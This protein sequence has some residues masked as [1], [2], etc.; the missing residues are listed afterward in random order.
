MRLSALVA[1]RGGKIDPFTFEDF[2][3]VGNKLSTD[4]SRLILVGGQ[5]LETWG[6]YFDVL[7]PTG[8][9]H[10]LTEDTDWLGGKRDAQW[11]CQLL[12]RDDTELTFATGDDVGT[13]SAL[14]Y[15]KRPDGRVLMMDF[16]HAIVGP[17]NE[18]IRKLAVSIE[19][20][21]VT[22]QVMHPLLCLESRLENLRLLP[23]KRNG[24]GVMQAAWAINIVQAYIQKMLDLGDLEQGAKACRK[25]AENAEYKAGRYCF[26]AFGLDPLQAVSPDVVTRIGGRFETIEWP[27][28]M[29]R[30]KKKRARWQEIAA[31]TQ[32]QL[33]AGAQGK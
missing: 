11:L 20:S 5:A 27:K 33:A 15:L 7:A 22:L 6:I 32:P 1:K 4:P 13:S 24:N 30:I 3:F 8:D 31:R 16:L 26:I 9:R 21:G 14:A 23:S 18:E 29:T 28:V 12:G 25:V 2:L 19:V 17:S 10:P